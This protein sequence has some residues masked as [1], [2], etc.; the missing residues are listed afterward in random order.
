[1]KRAKKRRVREP[2][3]SPFD[4]DTLFQVACEAERIRSGLRADPAH[5]YAARERLLAAAGD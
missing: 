5:N 1:M 3:G 4:F 2:N